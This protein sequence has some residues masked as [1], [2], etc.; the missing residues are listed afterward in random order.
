MGRID[1]GR[2]FPRRPHVLPSSCAAIRRSAESESV[3]AI[4]NLNDL[5]LHTLRDVAHAEKQLQK[6]LPK[7]AREAADPAL[8]QMLERQA[9]EV[10]AQTARLDAIFAELGESTRGVRCDAIAGLIDEAEALMAKVE[11]PPTMDLGLAAICRA[12]KHYE[13]A[14]YDA[15]AGWADALGLSEAAA[16][17]R[18]TLREEEAADAA[19]AARAAADPKAA[20]A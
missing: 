4:T 13:I 5:F 2:N 11:D 14:R 9:T 19:L 18:E 12:V 17:L 10:G 20:A 16:L 1:V 15:L 7:I 6:A 8:K 3:M